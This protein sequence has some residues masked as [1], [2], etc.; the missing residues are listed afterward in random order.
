MNSM[1]PILRE[2]G[3]SFLN[4]LFPPIC[5][6]CSHVL[7]DATHIVCEECLLSF[8]LIDPGERCP[9]CFSSDYCAEQRV[10]NECQKIAPV[11]H[12]IASAFDYLGPAATMLK[13]LKYGNQKY[14]AR[15]CAGYL[16]AQF[17]RLDWP[18]PDVIIPVPITFNH[19]IQRGYNQCDLLAQPLGEILQCPVMNLLKRKSGDY[20]QAGLDRDQRMQLSGIS[21]ELRK[22]HPLYDKTILLIDDVMTTGTTLRKCAEQLYATHPA[23]IYG[24]TFCRAI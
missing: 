16:A 12:R 10:C 1:I 21:F 13:Q 9:F 3:D 20:S 4:L 22:E 14:L 2:C 15:G 18:M 23:S 11:L 17:L 19:W 8:E 5:I 24:L 6:H 7:K